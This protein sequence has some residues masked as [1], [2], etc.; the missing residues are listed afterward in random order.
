MIKPTVKYC[1]GVLGIIILG[2]S[3]IFGNDKSGSEDA[4]PNIV[5]FLA[6]DLGYG[7]LNSYGGIPDTPNIDALA[8]DGLK[9]TDFYA[10]APN[11]S[12]SRAGLLTG[13]NPNRIGMYS[14]RRPDHS[15]HLKDEEITI[16]EILKQKDYATAL[17]GKWHLSDL[18]PPKASG[19]QPRP[20]DQ[21]FDYWLATENNAQP[22]HY[23]PGNFVRNG[24]VEDTL[25]GYSSHII[26]RKANQWVEEQNSKQKPFLLYISFHEVHKKIASPNSLIRKYE[27]EKNPEYQA[28]VEN[29]DAAVG[30]IIDKL[31]EK[32]EFTNTLILFSSD[33]GSYR[34]G[35]NG[36]LRGYKGESFEGGVRVPGIIHWP[37]KIKSPRTIST[38]AGL[39]DLFPTISQITGISL[40]DDRELDGVSLD[41]LFNSEPLNRKKPLFWF[42]YRATPEV[43]MRDGK[44]VLNAFTR[45]TVCRTHYLSDKAMSFIKSAELTDFKLYDIG[46]DP[47]QKNDLSDA[48]PGI[49]DSL[50][51]KSKKLFWEILGNGPSWKNLP[52]HDPERALPKQN[53]MRNQEV[54]WDME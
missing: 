6:D 13:R 19:R 46:N 8:R 35:S 4:T 49:L 1:F 10:P 2:L 40:P 48:R 39:I 41:P 25:K 38:P 47:L 42:F 51:T 53:F 3:L 34:H 29:M 52:E 31:K 16:A 22:S 30:K 11:C 27:G 18:G 21:G 54:R 43:G 37:E 33:N 32:G 5:I 44:Y 12:P 15:M 9:F 23:N 20:D 14:Y 7:D 26:A 36:R 50:K 28:N 17:F 45:D 24:E